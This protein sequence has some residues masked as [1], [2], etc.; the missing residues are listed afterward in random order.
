MFVAEYLP[1]PCQRFASRL[2]AQVATQ[3]HLSE[4]HHGT[5]FLIAC[6]SVEFGLRLS[7][8]GSLTTSVLSIAADDDLR[9]QYVSEQPNAPYRMPVA[10]RCLLRL[11]AV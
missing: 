8:S 7:Y 6:A 2:A 4:F 9:P 10:S 5:H 3:W 11:C 1:R